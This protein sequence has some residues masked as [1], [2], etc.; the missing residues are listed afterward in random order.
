MR[1][2][3]GVGLGLSLVFGCLFLA[4][5]AE[6]Y[7]LLWWKKRINNR[8]IEDDYT[9][10]LLYMFCFRKPSSL[11]STALTPQAH[12]HLH[13]SNKDLLLKPFGE[14]NGETELIGLS[15][16]PR[17]LFTIKE[18]TTEDLESEDGISKSGKGSRSKSLSDFLSMETPFLTPLCSPPFY[19]PPLTPHDNHGFSF[20]PLFESVSDA[21]FNKMRLSPPPKFKFLKDAEEKLYR[22]RLIEENKKRDQ[23]N[24]DE[25]GSFITIII[26]K[27]T[28][29]ERHNNQ[30]LP[31]HH[32]SSSQVLPLASSPSPSNDKP[33]VH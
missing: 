30:F 13:H 27:S 14:E 16:P 32:S 21:E 33:S 23:K 5:L 2:L 1:S 8:E 24:N 6:L 10:S 15:G 18:E 11:S 3:S 31:Q 25:D 19:T 26:G 12:I 20:N 22:R 9:T 29:R 4:L 17:F 7:Y 28:E